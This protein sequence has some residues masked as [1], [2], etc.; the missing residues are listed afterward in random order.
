[1]ISQFGDI[2]PKAVIA[3]ALVYGAVSWA[4][5][6]PELGSRIIR[7]DG[8][9]NG[10]T[11]LVEQQVEEQAEAAIR[12]IPKPM[13]TPQQQTGLA[14]LDAFSKSQFGRQFNDVLGQSGLSTDSI[15]AIATAPL[16]GAQ[17]AYQDKVDAVKAATASRMGETAGY[18]G[19]LADEV[20]QN[21]RNDWAIYAGTLTFYKP[22]AITDIGKLMSNAARGGACQKAGG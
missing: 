3:G 13:L 17:Q 4:I 14:F 9:L 18:C 19:C 22:P 20:V 11:K 2:A 12:N 1:M 8:Y 10:C 7:A 15:G 5:T 16:A 21:N 6:G